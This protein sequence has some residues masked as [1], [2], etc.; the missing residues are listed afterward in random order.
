[1]AFA[2]FFDNLII[3]KFQTRLAWLIAAITILIASSPIVSAQDNTAEAAAKSNAEQDKK[4]AEWVSSLSLGD[5]SKQSRIAAVITAH[6][7]AVRDWHNDHPY[8]TVPAG[9]NPVTGQ[10]LSQ[11]DRSMIADSAM[12]KSVHKNLMDG[13]RADLNEEQVEAILDKYTVGKV[14]FTMK[15]YKAI[16]PDLTADEEKTILGFLKQAREEAVSYKSMPQI[17]AIF[18]IYKTKSEQYLNSNGRDWK[19]LYKAYSDAAK[20]KKAQAVK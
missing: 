18:E 15:G 2:R 20:A 8:T 11:L 19:K 10:P 14:A 1:V 3:M 6:L 12:P 17:S 13:L 9:I 4:A 7:K 16:V 5:D